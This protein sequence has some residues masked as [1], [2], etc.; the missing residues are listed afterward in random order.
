M[1]FLYKILILI[2]KPIEWLRSHDTRWMDRSSDIGGVI[3]ILAVFF[4]AVF[5]GQFEIYFG[6]LFIISFVFFGLD[7]LNIVV[8]RERKRFS[9]KET[10]DRAV[11]HG[12]FM[13]TGSLLIALFGLVGLILGIFS[14]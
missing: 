10:G 6:L 8:K 13:F 1:M 14:D 12:L 9:Y 4:S 11:A 7:G 3:F 2:N 5:K